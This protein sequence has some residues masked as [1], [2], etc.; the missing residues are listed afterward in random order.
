MRDFAAHGRP[1]VLGETAPLL[2]THDRWRSFLTGTRRF[3]HGSLFFYDGRREDEVGATAADAWYAAGLSTFLTFDKKGVSNEESLSVLEG[4]GPRAAHRAGGRQQCT[5]RSQAWSLAVVSGSG[6]F[7]QGRA[8]AGVTV[9][10]CGFGCNQAQ[11]DRFVTVR[12]PPD[13]RAA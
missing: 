7:H 8:S 3:V 2:T 1:V 9:L 11:L 6:L 10:S 4:P 13:R 5:G 12:R